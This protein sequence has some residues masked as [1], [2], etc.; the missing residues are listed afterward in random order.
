MTDYQFKQYEELRD[1]CDKL[2]RKRDELIREVSRLREE[3]ARLEEKSEG[4]VQTFVYTVFSLFRSSFFRPRMIFPIASA[5]S[6]LESKS[7]CAHACVKT[8]IKN[9]KYM[10]S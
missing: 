1:K 4:S 9:Y 3:N 2:T 5:L 6:S 8:S 7:R 10:M